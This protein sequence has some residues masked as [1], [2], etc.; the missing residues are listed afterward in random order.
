MGKQAPLPSFDSV[1]AHGT[2]RAP[3]SPACHPPEANGTE[4]WQAQD[5]LSSQSKRRVKHPL[6]TVRPS[7]PK[8]GA[9]SREVPTLGAANA[10]ALAPGPG[11]LERSR[12]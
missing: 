4:A 12:T 9:L 6:S 11:C 8:R 5:T 1:P 2:S 7:R 10:A 3:A